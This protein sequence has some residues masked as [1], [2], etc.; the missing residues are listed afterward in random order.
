MFEFVQLKMKPA[1]LSLSG[2]KFILKL[3][4]RLSMAHESRESFLISDNDDDE[5][6][7]DDAIALITIRLTKMNKKASMYEK[8]NNKT[9]HS[10]RSV[11][12]SSLISMPKL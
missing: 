1:L 5:D 7:E 2:S 9:T 10:L 11:Q 8:T 3:K 6:A 12:F 4:F